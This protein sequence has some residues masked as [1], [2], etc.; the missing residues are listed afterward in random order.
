MTNRQADLFIDCRND[1]GE[2]PIWHHLRN[3][4]FWFDINGHRL[5]S[6]N[7]AGELLDTWQFDEP[8]SAAAVVDGE[9]LLVATATGLVR[10]FPD[11]DKRETVVP[12][13]ADN[14][15][16]RS[17]DGRVDRA[18]GFWIG[19]MSQSGDRMGGS[20]YRYRDGNIETLMSGI[21]VP[22]ATCFAPDGSFAYWADTPT[23]KLL[24]CPLDRDTGAPAGDWE[25]LLDTT[26]HRGLPDGA[27]TDSQGY[28]W[29]ARWGGGCVVRHAPDGAIDMVVD[30]PASNVTCPAFGGADL[31]TLYITTARAELSPGELADQP[32]AGSVFSLRVDVPG[33]PEMPVRI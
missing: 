25:E 4:L 17:N 18:G 15:D 9:S 30:V 27:V 23:G 3:E 8:V 12:L 22:N 7:A 1:L 5:H 21:H 28:I 32:H 14:T 20:V 19:T 24:R 2:G 11:S 6:A 29:T 26:G 33:S 13:E 31:K 16:T 10:F